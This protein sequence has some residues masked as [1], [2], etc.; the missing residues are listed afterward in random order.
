MEPTRIYVKP[1]L[2]VF[3]DFDVHGLAHI[4]GGGL[5]ENIPRVLPPGLVANIDLE[6]WELPP[7]FAWLAERGP[8][9]P[10]ELLRTFNCGIGMA[11]IVAAEDAKDISTALSAAGETIL[12][13][14]E[15]GEPR[16]NG[17]LVYSG[18]LGNLGEK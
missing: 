3:N 17:G 14:G 15:I 9:A 6:S 4:T 11:V 2:G 5:T 1:L 16:A 8:I 12:E 18:Q 13:I 7:I 10:L